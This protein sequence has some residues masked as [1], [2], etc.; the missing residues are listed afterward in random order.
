MPAI[1]IP[2]QGVTADFLTGVHFAAAALISVYRRGVR[3]SA[4]LKG[5]VRMTTRTK[6]RW[7]SGIGTEKRPCHI[8]SVSRP[9]LEPGWELDFKLADKG[10]LHLSGSSAAVC[11]KIRL[12]YSAT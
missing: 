5:S 12:P 6:L 8:A 9:N 4:S 10:S 11:L 1:E 3:T 2:F 7:Q